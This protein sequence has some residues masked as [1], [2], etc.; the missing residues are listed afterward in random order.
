MNL[1]M[2]HRHR[3]LILIGITGAALGMLSSGYGFWLSLTAL[4]LILFTLF[5]TSPAQP[6]QNITTPDQTASPGINKL[7]EMIKLL[8]QKDQG[9]I[10]KAEYEERRADLIY[11]H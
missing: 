8:D 9:T 2:T 5:F 10:T 3:W 7:E 11:N 4:L 6:R 1:L